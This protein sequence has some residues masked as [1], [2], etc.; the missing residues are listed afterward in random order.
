MD[1]ARPERTNRVRTLA[2]LPIYQVLTTFLRETQDVFAWSHED[3]LRIDPSI[4]VQYV[5]RSVFA[6]ERDKAITKDVRK[7][8]EANFF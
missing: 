2:S 1:N 4:I 3:M 6:Q 7:L 5:R 8:Q